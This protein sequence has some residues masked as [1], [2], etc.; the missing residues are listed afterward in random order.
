VRGTDAALR[1]I[2]AAGE[3]CHALFISF[4][5][6][7][8]S[9]NIVGGMFLQLNT[10][11]RTR[12][13]PIK[14]STIRRTHPKMDLNHKLHAPLPMKIL[15]NHIQHLRTSIERVPAPNDFHK[16]AGVLGFPSQMKSDLAVTV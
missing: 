3:K 10:Y 1:G 13:P 9:S 12:K 2:D 4:H 11:L 14:I 8:E 5:S 16:M 6:K 15:C 7:L